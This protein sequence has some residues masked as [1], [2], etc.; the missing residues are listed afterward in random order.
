MLK[1]IYTFD[2]IEGSKNW[3]E[4]LSIGKKTWNKKKIEE[5]KSNVESDSLRQSSILQELLEFQK[6]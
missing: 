6:A 2:M 3:S 4:L 5:V 1:E